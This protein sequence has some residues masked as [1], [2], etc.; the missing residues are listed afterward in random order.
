MK[1]LSLN[2]Y[3]L[4]HITYQNILEKTFQESI[5]EAEFYSL[6]LTDYF[7]QDFLGRLVHLLLRQR[8][9]GSGKADYD[10]HRLRTEVANSFFARRCLERAIKKYQPDVLHVHTQGI[11]LL[12]ASL[13]QEIPSVISIDCTTAP[14]ATTHP[15]PA[16]LTYQ[17]ILA[18][19]KQCF[20]NAAHVVTCSDWARKS[21]IQDYAISPKKVT[22]IPYGMPLE[23][24]AVIQRPRNL[25][26]KK[27]CLLFVGNDFTRKGG[28]DLLTVF[29]E[30][31]VDTCELN[32]VTNASIDIPDIPSIRVHKGIRP[33]SPELF[34]LYQDAD[35]FVLPTHEDVYG[36]VFIEAMA[37]GLPCVGTTVMAVPELVQ[38]GVN[39]FTVSP[40][41]QKSLSE[42]LHKLVNS[43]EIRLS[44]GLAGRKIAEQTFDAKINCRKIL[45]IFEKC[46]KSKNLDK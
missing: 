41:D 4:G 30:N 28:Y 16:H 25:T 21:V 13:F 39:G 1:I 5:P 26:S 40:K 45:N 36:V 33:M 15:S 9:P 32:I 11:A 14:L 46:L 29:L 23:K 6:H 27:T 20:K 7:K 37:A 38:N 42:V 22:T 3:I 12:S 31:F 34:Q 10:F 2:C 35:I 44:M 18:L 17:P 24:F 43:P 19:E 8:F